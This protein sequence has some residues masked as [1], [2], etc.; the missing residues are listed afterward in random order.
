MT[1]PR[2]SE[3]VE[4]PWGHEEIFAIVEGSY[5]G[6]TLHVK[7]GE[8]L[9]LQYHHHKDETIAVLSGEAQMDVGTEET[10]LRTVDL[11]AGSSIHVPPGLL[12]RVRAVT[13]AVLVEA[14]TAGPGWREDVVR[15]D[16]RYGRHGTSEP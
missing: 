2:V 9:S 5:V 6:K 15:L 14:S 7:A 10:S 3:R 12:H 16:D 13:D 8:A 11:P 1:E 4:K